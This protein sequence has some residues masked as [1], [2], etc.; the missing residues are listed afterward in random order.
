MCRRGIEVEKERERGRVHLSHDL[1]L[2][3]C[4]LLEEMCDYG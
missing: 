2:M 4:D 3:A 1:S